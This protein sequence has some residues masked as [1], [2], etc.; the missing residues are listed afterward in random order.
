VC[1]TVGHDVSELCCPVCKEF[2]ATYM[3]GGGRAGRPVLD[4]L[5]GRVYVCMYVRYGCMLL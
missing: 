4:A 3:G 2:S 5:A 1:Q